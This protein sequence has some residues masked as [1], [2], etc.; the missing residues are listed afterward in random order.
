MK[1]DPARPYPPAPYA[2]EFLPSFPLTSADFDDGQS[3]P[4][5]Q[6][7]TGGNI[8]PRLAWSGFP[9]ATKS[10]L[11]TATDPDARRGASWHWVLSDVPVTVTALPA[12]G[13]RTVLQVLADAIFARQRPMAGV[14]GS[15]QRRN[16]IGATGFMGAMPPKGD[17]AHRYVFAVHAL[18]VERLDVPWKAGP[19]EVLAAAGPHTLARAV[20][21]GTNQR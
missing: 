10:F 6:T 13:R 14:S 11:V 1:L 18:D 5:G 15:L 17:H 19:R 21:T 12:G 4:A 7:A 2:G 20:L 16:S 9:E 8:S 3:L